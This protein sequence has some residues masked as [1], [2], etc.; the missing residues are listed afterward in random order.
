MDCTHV[1]GS[2]EDYSVSRLGAGYRV[3]QVHPLKSRSVAEQSQIS[4]STN[5]ESVTSVLPFIRFEE[6]I[7]EHIFPPKVL[8]TV[9][10]SP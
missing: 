10:T 2:D 5:H 9:Q 1:E 4:S 3:P 6:H 8:K 7:D